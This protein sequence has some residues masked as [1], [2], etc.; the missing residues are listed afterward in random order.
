MSV[1]RY[2]SVSV[3]LLVVLLLVA[4]LAGQALGQPILLSFVET[5]SM[6]PTLEPGDG[7]VAI[8]AELAGEPQRGDVITFNAQELH[9]GGLTTHRVVGETDRGYI[10]HGDANPVTDQ[11]GAEPPVQR[12]QIVAKAW[13]VNG[14]VVVIPHLGTAAMGLQSGVES[15]QRR[16]ANMVGTSALLGTQGL[17]YLLAA[18]SGIVYAVDLW[19]T[20]G[21]KRTVD[22]REFSRSRDTGVSMRLVVA[23]CV[24]LVLLA[25]T[26]A[27]VAPAGTTEY[28]VVS[29]QFDSDRPTVIPSGETETIDYGVANAGMISTYVH[30]AGASEGVTVEPD[31]LLVERRSQANATVAL[32]APSETGYYLMYVQEY[33][34]LAVLPGSVIAEL[35]EIHPWLPIV[36]INAMLGIPIYLLGAVLLGR[37]SIR[38]RRWKRTGGG[39]SRSS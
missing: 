9:G 37:G 2:L 14:D 22:D 23:G 17:A 36:A 28:G 16:L 7:F 21:P 12:A 24:G 33:R 1:R 26:A 29:A 5:G 27:M 15:L 10:T 30:L 3:Q 38:D 19:L 35:Y 25:A 6:E 31:V 4:L 39:W 13:Q 8:P 20:R 32:T 34:Y 11:A 18:L